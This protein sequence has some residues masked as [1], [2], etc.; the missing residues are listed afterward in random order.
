MNSDENAPP[1]KD[2]KTTPAGMLSAP[3]GFFAG[4][5][6]M[7]SPQVKDPSS[8]APIATGRPALRDA[9]ASLSPNP[10]GNMNG[11]QGLGG[12]GL[13]GQVAAEATGDSLLSPN[14]SSWQ[15]RGD[16]TS[17]ASENSFVSAL[18]S[19]NT[20][21]PDSLHLASPGRHYGAESDTDTSTA[22]ESAGET[23]GNVSGFEEVFKSSEG[24]SLNRPI[25]VSS[26]FEENRL[27]QT[28]EEGAN[29]AL[30][31]TVQLENSAQSADP[32]SVSFLV[33]HLGSLSLST[34]LKRKDDAS[35]PRG[36]VT[37]ASDV[38]GDLNSSSE[39]DS[40]SV[41]EPGV[42]ESLDTTITLTETDEK[43]IEEITGKD[44]CKLQ[45]TS[46]PNDCQK[47]QDLN[48]TVDIA[49]DS[50]SGNLSVV[51]VEQPDTDSEISAAA[52]K[53]LEG[54]GENFNSSSLNYSSLN[55][56]ELSAIEAKL[57]EGLD[58]SY[59]YPSFSA[60]NSALYPEVPQQNLAEH[61]NE[62]VSL[63]AISISQ[64]SSQSESEEIHSTLNQTVVEVISDS[65]S[66]TSCEKESP[67]THEPE[68][69]PSKHPEEVSSSAF[70]GHCTQPAVKSPEA[71]NALKL[72]N[73]SEVV[74]SSQE[75]TKP[76]ETN[77]LVSGEH[78][79][80]NNSS[81]NDEVM[82]EHRDSFEDTP[83]V[84]S[85]DFSLP[86]PPKIIPT[87]ASTFDEAPL[88][89]KKQR[90]FE[91]ILAEELAAQNL[92]CQ[93]T[94]PEPKTVLVDQ[95]LE[96]PA[97]ENSTSPSLVETE[98][99]T[100]LDESVNAESADSCGV[101]QC[102]PETGPEFDEI[103]I[104]IKPARTFEEILEAELA[105]EGDPEN[106]VPSFS[107][108]EA[109]IPS[110]PHRTFEEILAAQLAAGND[111]EQAVPSFSNLNSSA[112]SPRKLN[113]SYAQLISSESTFLEEES[114]PALILDAHGELEPES[115]SGLDLLIEKCKL[116]EQ[117]LELGE[118][119]F[120]D[121]ADE[122]GRLLSES[123]RAGSMESLGSDLANQT[124]I[125]VDLESDTKSSAANIQVQPQSPPVKVELEDQ[126]TSGADAFVDSSGF[127]FLSQR[128]GSNITRDF[129]KE[130]LYVKFDP[131]V[132]SLSDSFS[133]MHPENSSDNQSGQ[134]ASGDEGLQ[135]SE[136]QLSA[137]EKLVSLSPSSSKQATA[138]STPLKGAVKSN[139]AKTPVHVMLNETLENIGL[140]GASVKQEDI[141]KKVQERQ[142]VLEEQ[143]KAYQ[144]RIAELEQRLQ[145]MELQ[146]SQGDKGLV[147][148]LQQQLQ[149]KTQSLG[150][151]NVIMKEY[152]KTISRLVAEKSQEKAA[153]DE[154]QVELIKE[155]DQAQEHLNN[156]EI[157]FSDIHTKYERLKSVVEVFK[158]NEETLN[159]ALDQ[160]QANYDKMQSMYDLLK[161]HAVAKLEKANQDLEAIRQKHQQENAKLK[162]MIKKLEIKTK[163][164]EETLEQKVKENQALT[165]ICD[166]LINKVGE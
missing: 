74:E 59:T 160:K 42:K 38:S 101:I 67:S 90:T 122:A 88:P 56:S 60:N 8:D 57:L 96:L 121:L 128:G 86:E 62:S 72:D 131:L 151:L 156:M 63:P 104:P 73:S 158:T 31:E 49:S 6:A 102:S 100:S 149:E 164:L 132:G 93:T 14:Q 43:E 87:A 24:V 130:S 44:S 9:N 165:A 157:A 144:E 89:T 83:L 161:S 2:E 21:I 141:I 117:D 138:P 106:A 69:L 108:E 155:R 125:K 64:D 123:Q 114:E 79:S 112:S 76:V 159:A 70:T 81:L 113:E 65:L 50:S 54:L 152:E 162:A 32:L 5:R 23:E 45:E 146:T 34:P 150:E 40:I 27:D 99:T 17:V 51:E 52:L 92:N 19:G 163:S 105:A 116:Q 120:K 46:I 82:Q 110:N 20:S 30:N 55:Y 71:E 135:S 66:Q 153:S 137:S 107:A 58:E 48:Q 16:R 129:R 13:G 1:T 68:T 139:P 25:A 28:Y 119:E 98:S 136:S 154:K 148:Q 10:K 115:N 4:V 85:E 84:H 133:I 103:A 11:A 127:D 145:E 12:Q 29:T 33:D 61:I 118:S 35:S 47:S 166:E 41:T 140:R 95:P 77:V 124:V 147:Q 53:E 39:Q 80:E 97:V 15:E 94:D 75:L 126:F 91:E 22:Y 7:L 37:L 134:T 109:P 78:V 36:H 3:F 143:D 26:P 18:S 111:P 142:S